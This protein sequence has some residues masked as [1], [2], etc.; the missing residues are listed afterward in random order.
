MP[1]PEDPPNNP[2][3][4]GREIERR[5]D[6]GREL[7][8]SIQS[9]AD[10]ITRALAGLFNPARDIHRQYTEMLV[11][12]G[13]IAAIAPV[14]L[15]STKADPALAKLK[16]ETLLRATLNDEEYLNL[17]A[18]GGFRLIHE[19]LT[20]EYQLSRTQKTRVH[21]PDGSIYS[22][23]IEFPANVG[24]PYQDRLVAEYLLILGDE[25]EYLRTANLSWVGG[26]RPAMSPEMSGARLRN[27]YNYGVDLVQEEYPCI[28]VIEHV[29]IGNLPAHPREREAIESYS[30]EFGRP[31]TWGTT[32]SLRRQQRWNDADF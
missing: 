32:V 26:K 16:A 17:N 22:A 1:E 5:M 12:V 19:S 9:Q 28:P 8:E 15:H 14:E 10:Q 18:S 23:C 27:M 6:M 13:G 20:N 29:T 11:A 31:P 2:P 25:P 4:T 30:R 21:M 3:L 7:I 24:A